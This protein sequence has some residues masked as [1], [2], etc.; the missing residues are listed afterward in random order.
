MQQGSD[1]KTALHW[2]AERGLSELCLE[3][4]RLGGRALLF[5]VDTD[6]Q[7]CLHVAAAR[8]LEEAC[9]DMVR[10][11]GRDVLLAQVCSSA[12]FFNPAVR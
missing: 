3:M 9:E 8:G 2:V 11:G 12:V 10:V 7:T 4:I 1:G 5:L 6:G